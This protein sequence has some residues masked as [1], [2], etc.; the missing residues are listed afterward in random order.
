[1][2]VYR[3]SI[4]INPNRLARCPEVPR[5]PRVVVFSM[6]FHGSV[7]VLG[8]Q[9]SSNRP[10]SQEVCIPIIKRRLKPERIAQFGF[11]SAYQLQERGP[12]SREQP[13]PRDIQTN[14]LVLFADV[15]TENIASDLVTAFD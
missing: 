14:E 11:P 9:N 5:K 6:R 2:R 8:S 1:M 13:A 4:E 3:C 12:R 15:L 10:V 7:P